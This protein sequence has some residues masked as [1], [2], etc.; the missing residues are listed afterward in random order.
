VEDLIARAMA[1]IATHGIWAGPIIGLLAFGESL[2]VVGLFIPATTLMIALGGLLGTGLLDPLPIICWAVCGA[3][4]GDWIS[5][6]IGRRIGPS[7]YRRWPLNR[8]RP[9]VARARLFFRRFGFVSIFFGRFLGPIR[10]IIPLVGGVMQMKPRAFQIANI[11]S[12]IVWVPAL[13]AP[14][15]LAAKKLGSV[16]QITEM[17]LFAFAAASLLL[18]VVATA[19]AA[20]ILGHSRKRPNRRRATPLRQA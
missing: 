3:V 7:I 5:Y 20:R 13:L 17:H 12:A 6:A 18:T 1:I 8:N 14:G 2:V 9:M 4:L 19:V 10:A 15:Y 16:A 11:T